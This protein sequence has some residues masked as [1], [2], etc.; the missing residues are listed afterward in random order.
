MLDVAQRDNHRS[1]AL[2]L[3][4][5]CEINIFFEVLSQKTG[6]YRKTTLI[7]RFSM[8]EIGL[9]VISV[10]FGAKYSRTPSHFQQQLACDILEKNK[11]C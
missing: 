3:V 10:K 11:F 4:A 8:L 5:Q 6:F 1:P 9:T 7:F 2:T